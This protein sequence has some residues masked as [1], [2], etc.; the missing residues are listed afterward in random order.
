MTAGVT[1][2]I[3]SESETTTTAGGM[4][5]TD[6]TAVALAR[7]SAVTEIG[8]E[9]AS[10]SVTVQERGATVGLRLPL[11]R[12]SCLSWRMRKSLQTK[13]LAPLRLRM[14][15]LR[16]AKP[17]WRHGRKL[18][19][20]PSQRKLRHVRWLWQANW[21]LLVRPPVVFPI[22]LISHHLISPSDRFR[23]RPQPCCIQWARTQGPCYEGGRFENSCDCEHG[24][25]G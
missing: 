7:A 15:R 6:E 3:V 9:T 16:L 18:R 5:V 25:C 21:L 23:W 4:V 1:V 8:T 2:V 12:R 13:R 19:R 11:L 22:L 10:G 14:T 20:S 17:N 24:R